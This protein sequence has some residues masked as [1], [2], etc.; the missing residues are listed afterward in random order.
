MM[1]H[2]SYKK[3][4]YKNVRLI[5]LPREFSDEGAV[6]TGI[7]RRKILWVLGYQTGGDFQADFKEGLDSGDF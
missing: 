1:K 2:F 3:N 4:I 7:F 5:F 6:F